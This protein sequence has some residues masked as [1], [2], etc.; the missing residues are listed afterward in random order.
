MAVPAAAEYIGVVL[1]ASM[2]YFT[3]FNLHTEVTI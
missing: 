3:D 2:S 1:S